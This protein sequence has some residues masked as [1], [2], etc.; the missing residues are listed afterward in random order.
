MR[1]LLKRVCIATAAVVVVGLLG[2][3][4]VLASM[5]SACATGSFGP[6]PGNTVLPVDCTG[7]DSGTLLQAM[8][9]PFSYATTSGTTSGVIYSAVYNDGGTL[10][11]YYQVSNDANSTDSLA[12]ETDSSFLG[13]TTFAAFLTN[14][15]SLLGSGFQNGDTVPITADSN[16]DG[17]VIGFNFF[18]PS[19]PPTEIA[20][21][22][23]SY[24]LIIS[25]NATQ[26]TVG[27]A[28]VIDGGTATVAAFQP[29]TSVPE[30]ASLALL[31]FGLVGLAGFRRFRG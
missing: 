4:P 8:S 1:V 5:I 10:D 29:M 13:F 24:V 31:G 11:F 14:G 20:P 27:N 22:H 30:P 26:Y 28:S 17:S 2:V 15:S 23:S 6:I 3:S 18:P 16:A 21:G 7:N 25:T 9:A 19:S 12:R